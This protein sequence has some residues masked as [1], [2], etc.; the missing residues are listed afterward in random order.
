MAQIKIQPEDGAAQY[1]METSEDNPCLSCGACCQHF[2]VSFYA[3]EMDVVRPGGVPSD[4]VSQTPVAPMIACMKGTESG[5][6]RCVALLGEPGQPGIGCAIYLS[7]PTPCREYPVWGDDGEP[8]ADCQRL[9]AGL[10]LAPLM[11]LARK[12]AEGA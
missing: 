10:G 9:R 1:D 7:R 5:G 3:G 11:A 2:R 8:N 6:G 12:A 4:L